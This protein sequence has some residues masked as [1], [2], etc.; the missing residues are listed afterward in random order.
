VH[1]NS[2]VLLSAVAKYSR[3]HGEAFVSITFFVQ[4]PMLNY[5]GA[6]PVKKSVVKFIEEKLEAYFRLKFEEWTTLFLSSISRPLVV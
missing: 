3:G 5:S 1:I 2:K 6:G 4:V